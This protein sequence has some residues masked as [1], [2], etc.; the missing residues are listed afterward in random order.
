MKVRIK[1]KSCLILADAIMG[2]DLLTIG[3]GCIE[4]VQIT[5]GSEIR[6]TVLL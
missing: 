2:W 6:N 1:I 3:Q 4:L 5:V